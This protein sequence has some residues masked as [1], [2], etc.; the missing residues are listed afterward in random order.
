MSL[1]SLELKDIIEAVKACVTGPTGDIY[2]VSM[3]NTGGILTLTMSNG[4]TRTVPINSS[5]ALNDTFVPTSGQ[6]VFVLS[7]IP[8]NPANIEMD[9]NGLSY[10]PG[11]G[12]FNS[13]G[14]TITWTG[15]YPLGPTDSVVITY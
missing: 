15:A 9:V 6:T 11:S 4:T 10:S 12:A 2:V 14:A 13:A 3:T 8:V 7:T 1:N 5:A